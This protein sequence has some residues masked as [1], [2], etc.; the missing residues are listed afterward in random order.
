MGKLKMGGEMGGKTLMSAD[1]A[2]TRGLKRNMENSTWQHS[3]NCMM[4][5]AK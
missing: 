5:T 2:T 1:L 4:Q 3:A